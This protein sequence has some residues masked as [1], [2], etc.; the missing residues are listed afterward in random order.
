MGCTASR[1]RS[2]AF[3][4][5]PPKI[6]FN[7]P[8]KDALLVGSTVKVVGRVSDEEPIPTNSVEVQI[9][10]GAW[11]VLPLGPDGVFSSDL[12][13]PVADRRQIHIEARVT[14][15]HGAVGTAAPLTPTVDNVGPSFTITPVNDT[16]LGAAVAVVTF[17]EPVKEAQGVPLISISSG[18]VGKWNADSTQLSFLPL[19]FDR[20]YLLTVPGG[21]VVDLAGNPSG[22][23]LHERL[24]GGAQGSDH[25][26]PRPRRDGE[27]LRGLVRRGRPR[28]DRGAG[29]PDLGWRSARLRPLRSEARLAR[30]ARPGLELHHREHVP[31]EPG[32][33][34]HRRRPR[35]RARG[36]LVHARRRPLE[37]PEQARR[38]RALRPDRLAA[39]G[40]LP[41]RLRRGRRRSGRGR[42]RGRQG[43]GAARG[44]PRHHRPDP[45]PRA[46]LRR[47]SPAGA[48]TT[49]S[50]SR[51]PGR[52]SRRSRTPAPAAPRRRAAP[53][54]P[55]PQVVASSVDSDVTAATTQ[56]GIR[57]YTYQDTT[58][59]QWRAQCS[60]CP[61][62]ST[63]Y[64]FPV[65]VASEGVGNK[66][67]FARKQATSIEVLSRDLGLKTDCSDEGT[68]VGTVPERERSEE[69]PPA[70]RRRQARGALPQLGDA[71]PRGVLSRGQNCPKT[72]T[73]FGPTESAAD[74]PAGSSRSVK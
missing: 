49:T 44:S 8:A 28:G 24:P 16:I 3:R 43:R 35:R 36:R 21:T 15:V 33:P 20:R 9:D 60:S 62:C 47:G 70:P 65:A 32:R 37:R 5:A 26:H 56:T 58:K 59:T 23:G 46:S 67:L 1:S 13:L 34:R 40:A 4:T 45:S 25:Q 38:A 18:P 19:E 74:G 73:P 22:P 66:V 6:A 29:D 50:C 69:V 30:S 17:T 72:C 31:G 48:R 51:S 42:L 57:L 68:I 54:T 14:D 39:L 11:N 10:G 12:P 52:T 27:R 71:Q 63:S 7:L 55:T 64:L 41:G 53:T 2:S 61:S